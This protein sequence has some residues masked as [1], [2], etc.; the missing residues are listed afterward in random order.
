MDT[1]HI[2]CIW[3]GAR[4]HLNI[5]ND[6]D[7]IQQTTIYGSLTLDFRLS[8][9]SY[10]SGCKQLFYPPQQNSNTILADQVNNP[11]ILI[12]SRNL[13]DLTLAY[14]SPINAPWPGWRASF[15]KKEVA[16]NFCLSQHIFQLPVCFV[17][18]VFLDEKERLKMKTG[19]TPVFGSDDHPTTAIFAFML[20]Y[21]TLESTRHM[22]PSQS[23][24]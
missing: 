24:L 7:M 8:Y 13:P 22:K 12:S 23:K 20:N 17:R 15:F 16:V 5:A 4:H 21:E 6:F 3:V 1:G 14:L 10:P 9:N 18:L 2:A 19:I 11:L